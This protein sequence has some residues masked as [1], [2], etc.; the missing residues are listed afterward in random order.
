MITHIQV[1][2]RLIAQYSCSISKLILDSYYFVH[3]KFGLV[4][5]F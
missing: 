1:L 4:V 3:K 5:L 2:F